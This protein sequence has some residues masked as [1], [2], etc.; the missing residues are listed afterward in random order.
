MHLIEELLLIAVLSLSTKPEV[1]CNSWYLGSL[2]AA[3]RVSDLGVILD[4]FA[5]CGRAPILLTI[6][7]YSAQEFY[8]SHHDSSCSGRLRTFR[9]LKTHA[10]EHP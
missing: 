4:Q 3:S 6:A 9:G 7:A 10:V 8:R 5:R 1:A 2:F